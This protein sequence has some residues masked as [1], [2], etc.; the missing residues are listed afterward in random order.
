MLSNSAP[1]FPVGSI[2]VR[3]KLLSPEATAAETLVVMIKRE[4]NFN[5]TAND[6]EFLTTSGDLKRIE[7][8]EKEGKCQQCHASQSWNDY[9]FRYP[10]AG[11]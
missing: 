3:E 6:W 10:P 7:A 9:V 5:P 2:I 4:R 8:R 1:R 11:R